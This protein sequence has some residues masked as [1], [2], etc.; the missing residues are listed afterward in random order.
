MQA[1]SSFDPKNEAFIHEE[2]KDKM[3]AN[4][5]NAPT[6][7]S[8]SLVSYH[9][10]TMRYEYTS[11]TSALAV[12]SEV[13]YD[14]GWKAYVDGEE[15]PIIRANYA[16]RALQLPGGNHK[17]EFIFAPQSMKISETISLI[18]SIILVLGLAFTIWYSYTQRN[19]KKATT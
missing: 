14:A 18:A 2:F 4:S 5:L 10:D 6:N 12:F 7:A 8:I 15:T 11:P 9:P 17:V 19:K 3:K 16:L 1:I 13:Y